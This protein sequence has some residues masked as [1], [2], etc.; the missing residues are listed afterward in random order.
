[1]VILAE[2]RVKYGFKMAKEKYEISQH[3]VYIGILID[4]QQNSNKI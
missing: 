4:T 2:A 1:M 3:K